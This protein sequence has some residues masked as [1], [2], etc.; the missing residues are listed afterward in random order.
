[1][2]RRV[3]LCAPAFITRV[4]GVVPSINIVTIDVGQEDH[5]SE[6]R[7]NFIVSPHWGFHLAAP[8]SFSFAEFSAGRVI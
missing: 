5:S 4:A 3:V 2:W 1:V 7:N 8:F 6:S